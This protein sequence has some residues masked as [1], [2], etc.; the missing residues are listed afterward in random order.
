MMNNDCEYEGFDRRKQC[1]MVIAL[2]EKHTAA[3]QRFN[4]FL[5]QY[6]EDKRESREF[7]TEVKIMLRGLQDDV[8]RLRP[9]V[10]VGIW[11]AITTIGAAII[12]GIGFL[13]T[14]MFIKLGR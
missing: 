4:Y 14:K 7:R 11:I 10:R 8:N 1:D 9:P 5:I 2:N 6:E 12:S 3:E 13:I